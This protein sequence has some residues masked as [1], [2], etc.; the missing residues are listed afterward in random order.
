MTAE[1]MIELL[2]MKPL[3]WE[4]GYYVETYRCEDK[5]PPVALPRRYSGE[6]E[7]CTAIL[8]LLTPDTFSAL[9]R[10]TSDEIF[11]WATQ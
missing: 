6:R 3:S 5:I 2:E 1:Q 11:T 8:Y 4:G 9:H 7:F 10:L